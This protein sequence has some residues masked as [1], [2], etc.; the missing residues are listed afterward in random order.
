MADP[1]LDISRQLGLLKLSSSPVASIS[2]LPPKLVLRV[3]ECAVEW[4]SVAVLKARFKTLRRT[5]LVCKAWTGPSQVLLLKEVYIHLQGRHLS[6]LLAA[7]DRQDKWSCDRLVISGGSVK[8][9]VDV[10]KRADSLDTLK[11]HRLRLRGGWK[12]LLVMS[13]LRSEWSSHA[14]VDQK[15]DGPPFRP[16]T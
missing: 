16:Q 11:V 12:G 10:V 13:C 14:V 7:I 4:N 1:D 8:E 6:S 5:S 9:P 2:A 15:T 3:L